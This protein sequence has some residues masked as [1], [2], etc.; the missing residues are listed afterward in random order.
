MRDNPIGIFDSGI[1]GLNVLKRCREL[2]PH[3]KFIY[4]ADSAH[5][6]YGKASEQEIK[7][8]AV[9]C[10]E[11]LFAMNCKAVLIA[12]NTATS[13]AVQDI[14]ALFANRVVVGLEP[15]IKPCYSE[16]GRGYAVALV[17]PATCSS[18]KYKRLQASCGDKIKSVACANLAAEIERATDKSELDTLKQGVFE[19][20]QPYKDA[21]AVILGCS[22][23][24]YIAQYIRDFYAENGRAVKIYDGAT[25]ACERLRYCLSIADLT[26]LYSD[27]GSVRFYST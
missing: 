4:L 25:G 12:C 6:P 15:A 8:A 9:M 3:E 21:E 24:S 26:A 23:Y 13:V 16:L 19:L 2:M 5:M 18:A 14:R 10:C 11:T 22:H 20:L 7:Q 1:G 27:Q 17:T